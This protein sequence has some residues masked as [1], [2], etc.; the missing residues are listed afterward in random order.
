M[1]LRV[2]GRYRIGRKLGSGSF[3]DIYFGTDTVTS[4]PVAIKLENV[5]TR[6]PQLIFESRLYKLLRQADEKMSGIPRVHW[7]GIEGEFNAMVLDL[8]GPSLEDLFRFCGRRFSVKTTLMLTEQI[9]TRVQYIHSRLFIHRDL[10]PDILLMGSGKKGH[11]VYVI[12]FGLAK[13]FCDVK[14]DEHIKY[15]EGKTLSGTARYASI[16]T[17]RGCEQ[18]RRDDLE[19]VA[20]ILLY[21][22]RGS[23]PWQSLKA[24][25][26]LDKYAFICEKKV[27]LSPETLC[28]DLPRE[29]CTFLQYTRA[30]DFDQAPDYEY[31][32]TLFRS[33]F[34][35]QGYK[36]DFCYDWIAKRIQMHLQRG[37]TAPPRSASSV[38]TDSLWQ[39]GVGMP[40][41]LSPG[42]TQPGEILEGSKSD[43]EDEERQK[44]RGQDLSQGSGDTDGELHGRR[45]LPAAAGPSR[46]AQRGK[47]E[48][49]SGNPLA[50][51]Q[52]SS[53]KDDSA[54]SAQ[55]QGSLSAGCSGSSS[56]PPVGG[57]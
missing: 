46:Q 15:R 25:S 27:A 30:L 2:N 48:L 47:A 45:M 6:H 7:F 52:G 51:R 39:S 54:D 49:G 41:E 22:L 28:R 35:R 50:G 10:K 34:I 36:L 5:R 38:G 14:T 12:D 23:L 33:L 9:L 8:L 29:F 32:K 40:P 57:H 31:L 19:S 20:Y 13:R 55:A 1:D 44:R 26:R 18:S 17:H 24:S 3:G 42:M 56:G 43:Q 37:M 11:Q 21:F 16:N 4:E 53:R